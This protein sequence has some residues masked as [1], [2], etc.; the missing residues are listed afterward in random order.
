MALPSIGME[1]GDWSSLGRVLDRRLPFQ[2]SMRAMKVEVGP[3]IEQLVF[4][5]RSRPE[6]RAIQVLA[7]NRSDQSF[8]K[9]MGQG[10]KGDGFDPGHLQD[11]QIGLPLPKPIKGSWS[12]LRYFGIQHCPRMA[13]LNIR[14]RATPSTVP[15]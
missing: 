2:C 12:Q 14:Q 1:T 4:K 5:I 13:R 11:P 6:Q 8:H 3:E 7:S 9:G 15:A 10:N